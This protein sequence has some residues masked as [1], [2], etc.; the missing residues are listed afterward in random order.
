MPVQTRGQKKKVEEPTVSDAEEIDCSSQSPSSEWSGGHESETA[1]G[2]EWDYTTAG[3]SSRPAPARRT[4]K[5]PSFGDS[6][7][8]AEPTAEKPDEESSIK[9]GSKRK[10]M[11]GG[12]EAVKKKKMGGRTESTRE[13]DRVTSSSKP[14][15]KG[16]T[17]RNQLQPAPEVTARNRAATKKET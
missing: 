1:G 7:S 9:I 12:R 2:D 15:E 10:R 14:P 5:P 8:E 13:N 6:G 4:Q 16:V 11:A 3:T 17:T